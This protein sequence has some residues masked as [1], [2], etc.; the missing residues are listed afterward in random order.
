MHLQLT[1]SLSAL[2]TDPQ[3][4]ANGWGR[5]HA[6]WKNAVDPAALL[7]S[8]DIDRRLD[9]SLLRWPYFTIVRNGEEPPSHAY[10]KTR[11]V[12]GQMRAGFP[13]AAKIRKMMFAEG[14]S[15]KLN[16]LSDWHRPT[17]RISE[18]L[19][20]IL[21]VVVATYAFWTPAER[22]GM[23]PHRDAAHVIA[24]QLEGCKEWHLYAKPEQVAST[25]GLHAVDGPPTHSF[26]LEPGDMLY[27]PH[28]WPHEAVAR[29]GSSLH[30]TF[31]MTE[32][33]P[34]DLVNAL[35]EHVRTESHELF[36]RH[37]ARALETKSEEVRMAL[38][39]AT[40][41]FESE[42]WLR[43]ALSAMAAAR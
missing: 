21:P 34:E 30:L 24:L 3:F 9:A 32:P 35:L 25:A 22:V 12:I 37:H 40:K 39:A 8:G 27:L 6:V 23:L 17:R 33:T 1:D 19:E 11:D 29:E 10:T 7:T 31:T 18:L 5:S 26:V 20:R 36:F 28:G 14:A 43:S 15:L 41:S 4:A 38:L 42:A 13:D 16:Q 2:L